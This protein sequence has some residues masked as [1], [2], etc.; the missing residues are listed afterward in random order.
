MSETRGAMLQS[1]PTE[2]RNKSNDF[3]ILILFCSSSKHSHHAA[4]VAQ[5]GGNGETRK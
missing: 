1:P 3:S 5:G 4:M 2:P